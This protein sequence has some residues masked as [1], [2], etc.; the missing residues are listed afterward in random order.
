M[1]R[2]PLIVSTAVAV[3]LSLAGCSAIGTADITALNSTT[4]A[5]PGP[6][7]G[8]T[9]FAGT[10]HTVSVEWDEAEYDAM[11]DAYGTDGSKDWIH[12][13]ITID[14][15]VLED[16]GVRLKGN[17]TLRGLE[18]TGGMGGFGGTAADVSADAPQTLPLLVDFDKYVDGQDYE[19]LTQ[20]AIRPGSPV[21]NEALAL[22]LT[23]ASGQAS[24][25]Y[26]YTTYSVNGSATE[27]R[28]VIENPDE[29]YADALDTSGVLFKADAESSFTY[30]GDDLATYEEQFKQLNAEGTADFQPIVDFLQ[31]MEGASD[32]EFD[33]GLADRVDVD[34]FA[35]YAATMNLLVNGD[36]MAGPGQ[37]YYLRYDLETR[38]ISVLSWDLNGALTGDASLSPDEEPTIGGMGGPGGVRPDRGQATD[39]TTDGTAGGTAGEA[40]PSEQSSA[41]AASGTVAGVTTTMVV[42][43]D[44]QPGGGLIDPG[45]VPAPGVPGS[46]G[47]DSAAPGAP[48]APGGRGGRGGNQLKERFLASEAFAEA[49]SSAYA[50]L[51]EQL[52]G[53]GTAA[54]V[55]DD[56]AASIPTSDALTQEEID[57]QVETVASFVE[58]R[59][60]ALAGDVG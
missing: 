36:D 45:A 12:A 31:W 9:L 40:A 43:Q 29:A 60:E 48:D 41:D 2:P 52:Y 3:A 6:A 22:A 28:L 18:G 13:T 50:D 35:R 49:Y 58:D 33:A 10:S 51:Y 47:Q 24:Q 21:V 23:A 56:I 1:P 46:G 44:D 16:V 11:I 27:T 57:Q 55:L 19:G 17:S 34:S 42:S 39:G 25:R 14:G 20:L 30:Q 15:T 54:D 32:E 26:A 7:T 4:G 59:T 8:S 5:V 38:K 37:N 53:S